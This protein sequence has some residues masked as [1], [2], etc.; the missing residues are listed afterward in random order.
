MVYGKTNRTFAT[1]NLWFKFKSSR[2]GTN[3]QVNMQSSIVLKE[4]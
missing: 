1:I 4:V 2:T 3:L